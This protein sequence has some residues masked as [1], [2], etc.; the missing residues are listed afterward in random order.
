MKLVKVIT[1]VFIFATFL[2]GSFTSVRSDSTDTAA[3]DRLAVIWT[4]GDADVA[5]TMCFM[6]THTAKKQRWFSDV[7]LIVWGP[8]ARLLAGDIKLQEKV[9]AMI[10]DGVKVQACIVC[11]DMYGVTDSLRAMGIE[12]K[13]MGM[14][15]TKMLKSD[16]KVLSF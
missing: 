3:R 8:S 5:H 14:P 9:R 12:V 10:E 11:A 1:I 6:Y 16:Y 7:T 2:G 15:L 13:G 4:S